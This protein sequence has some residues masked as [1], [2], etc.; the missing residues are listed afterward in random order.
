M[1]NCLQIDWLDSF[2]IGVHLQGTSNDDQNNKCGCGQLPFTRT[3]A[4]L[5]KSDDCDPLP[6]F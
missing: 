2:G 4:Q 5:L 6:C 1:K 3:V